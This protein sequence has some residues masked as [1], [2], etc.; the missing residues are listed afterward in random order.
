[1]KLS[2]SF[3]YGNQ[4]QRLFQKFRKWLKVLSENLHWEIYDQALGSAFW[5]SGALAAGKNAAAPPTLQLRTNMKTQKKFSHSSSQF[6]VNSWLWIHIWF[7]YN[8]NEYTCMNL[9][10]E[11]NL[12]MWILTYDFTISFFMIMNSYLNSYNEFINDL[13]IMNSYATFQDLWIRIWIHVHEEYREIIPEI[14][15]S[16]VPD[17]HWPARVSES[18]SQCYS[19]RW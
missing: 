11:M 7:H 14:K 18:V 9:L 1:M 12:Y 4:S 13:M 3:W 15:C 16:K 10:V 19:G 5:G 2:P 8:L 17:A 6:K